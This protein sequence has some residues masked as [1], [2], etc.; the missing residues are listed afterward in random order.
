M[1]AGLGAEFYLAK[2][3][4]RAVGSLP[5]RLGEQFLVHEMRAGAGCQITAVAHQLHAPQIDLPVAFDRIFDGIAGLCESGRIQDH[6]IV[7]LALSFQFR[8]QFKHVRAP[9]GHAVFH[10]IQAG[11]FTGLFAAQFGGV[12]AQHA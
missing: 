5:E 12:Y 3:P 1:V 10:L 4:V 11:V 9:E 8:K 2:P 7:G 6:H